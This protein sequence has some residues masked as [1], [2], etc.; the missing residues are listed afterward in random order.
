MYTV[1]IWGDSTRGVGSRERFLR[2]RIVCYTS[3]REE[4][5]RLNEV[6]GTSISN[7]N[8]SLLAH[9]PRVLPGRKVQIRGVALRWVEAQ[10]ILGLARLRVGTV[11]VSFR[12]R[13]D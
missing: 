11:K 7:R 3:I 13:V 5:T 4:C 10:V 6:G 12:A 9:H 2:R 8:T 1:T